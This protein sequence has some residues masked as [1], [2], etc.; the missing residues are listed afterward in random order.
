MSKRRIAP[1]RSDAGNTTYDVAGCGPA[2]GAARDA[3][4]LQ[5]RFVG[6]CLAKCLFDGHT[7]LEASPNVKILKY[8]VGEP[9]VFDDLQLVDEALWMSLKKL[10]S[11]PEEDFDALALAFE[12]SRVHRS[13][14]APDEATVETVELVDGGGDVAVTKA[15]L[16][17][18]FELRLRECVFEAHREELTALLAGF[19]ELV[20]PHVTL[21]LTA[22]EL[23]LALCGTP[24]LDLSDWRRNTVY[25]GA[26]EAKQADHPVC[27]AFWKVVDRWDD[28][29][30][31][32]LLQ[33]ATGSSRLPVGG[34]RN[35][36]Q[37]DG[38]SRCFTLTSLPLATAAYPRSH[39]CFNRIDLPLYDRPA[40]DMPRALEFVITHATAEFTMD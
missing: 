23:E 34:F 16:E 38:V 17:R 9:V 28:E 29:Q 1:R 6:R 31:A 32:R 8:L 39:T 25:K 11:I 18:F 20:P 13:H 2:R 15:N 10:R 12:V 30:R 3:L 26:F 4:L 33:W 27:A 40:V 19:H 7:C 35:L 22:R 5:Y 24:S 36:Q 21:L 37:R 14:S